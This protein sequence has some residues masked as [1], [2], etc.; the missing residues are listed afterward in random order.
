MTLCKVSGGRYLKR[1]GKLVFNTLYQAGSPGR[2]WAL[3]EHVLTG[4]SSY[5]RNLEHAVLELTSPKRSHPKWKL[6]TPQMVVRITCSSLARERWLAIPGE[7]RNEVGH[8]KREPESV[9]LSNRREFHCLRVGVGGPWGRCEWVCGIG[10]AAFTGA[11][12]DPRS[13]SR[14]IHG[15]SSLCSSLLP[16]SVSDYGQ[17]SRLDCFSSPNNDLSI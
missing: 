16:A 14:C 13:W 2:L 10:L 15:N 1:R 8:G 3:L 9:Q 6:T 7:T 5:H 4:V 11:L 17:D 12:S